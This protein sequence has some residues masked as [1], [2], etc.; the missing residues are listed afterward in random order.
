M[1]L[2]F[3]I[4]G[5]NGQFLQAL[6]ESITGVKEAQKEIESSGMSIQS[7]FTQIASSAGIAFSSI[8]AKSFVDKVVEM[9]S[10]FQDIESSMKVFL[11]SAEK[12]TKFMEELKDAAYYNMFEFTDLAKASQ[13]LIAYKND[14]DTVIPT[15]QKLSDIAVGTKAPLLDLVNLYNRAKNLGKV[16]SQDMAS[17]AVKGIVIRDVLKEMGEEGVGTTVTFEQLNKV[18]DHVTSE[19]G[20]FYNLQAEMMSNISAEIGQ[21]EDNLAS[22]FNEIGEKY[23]EEIVDVI[24]F[25]S[26]L[27]DNYEEIGRVIGE[28]I[29]IYGVYRVALATCLA[30]EKARVYWKGLEAEAAMMNSIAVAGETKKVTALTIAKMRLTN[31][32]K[33]LNKAILANPYVLAAA[34]VAG[35]TYG[36]YKLVTAETEAEKTERKLDEARQLANEDVQ[37]ERMEIDRLF[38]S[39]RAAKEGTEAYT[40]VKAEIQSKYRP[41][42]ESLKEEQKS[43]KDIEGAYRAI[44]Q[45]SRESILERAKAKAYSEMEE[46][47]VKIYGR[48]VEKLQQALNGKFGSEKATQVLREVQKELEETGKISEDTRKSVADQFVGTADYGN[49]SG[50]LS[51]LSVAEQSLNKG[52]EL[53]EQRFQIGEQE[54]K[55]Q[56]EEKVRD[57]QAIEDEKKMLQSELEA[58]STEEANGEKGL[59]IKKK[60][61]ALGKELRAYQ[62]KADEEEASRRQKKFELDQ[63]Q[64]EDEAARSQSARDAII[65]ARIAAIRN[66]GERE[67]AAED[68]QHRLNLQAIDDRE[69]EM[70]KTLYAYNKSVWENQNK[71][72]DRKYSDTEAGKAGWENLQL[73]EDQIAELTALRDKENAEYSRLV[74]QRQKDELSAMRDYLKQYGSFEQQKLAITEEYEQKIAEATTQGDKMRLEREK[75]TALANAGYQSISGGI[76]WKGLF[77]GIGNLSK[78]LMQPMM[79]QLQAYTQT[80][81]YRDADA[82][83]QKQVAELIQE[84]R[85]YVGSQ[86]V[87]WKDLAD[88]TE[89][90]TD[91]VVTYNNAVKAEKDAIAARDEYAAKKGKEEYNEEEYQKLV[92]KAEELGTATA[93]AKDSMQFFATNLSNASDEV[94]NYTSKLSTALN[95]AKGLQG[96]SGYGDI[97]SSIAGLDNLK[98]ALDS[99]LPKMGDGM[100]KTITQGMS[101]AISSGLDTMGSGLGSILSSGIGSVIGA[102]AHMAQLIMDMANSIKNFITGILNTFSEF[103]SL[104][105]IDDFVVA[106]CD[107][108]WN[109]IDTILDLP[110]N[111]YKMV[112]A[113]AVNGIGNLLNNTIGRIGNILSFGALSSGGPA[114]W[115]TNSNAEEVAETTKRLTEANERLQKSIDGLREEMANQ[116][117]YTA[118]N[119][120]MEAYDAQKAYIENQREILDTNQHYHN[121]HHS[122]AYNWTIDRDM[123]RDINKLLS[124]Y[125]EKNGK[126]ASWITPGLNDWNEFRDLSPEEMAYIRTH[127]PEIWRRLLSIGNYDNSEYFDAF[128]DL[129][130]SLEEITQDLY[131]VLTTTTADNVFNDFLDSL[132]DMANGAQDVMDDIADN[133]QEMVNKMVVNNLVGAQFQEKLKA[134]YEELAKVNKSRVRG[135]IDDAEYNRLLEQLRQ[136]YQGYV[137]EAKSEIEMFRDQGIIKATGDNDPYKQEASS[138][139]FQ[140]MSQDVGE[141]MNGRLTAL[142]IAGETIAAQA[143]NIYAEML[144]LTQV[145]TSSNAYLSDMRNM[146]ITGNSYLEDIAKYSKKMYLDFTVK[147]DDLVTQTKN[148]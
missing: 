59:E 108:I 6:R 33:A 105:W 124:E 102:F 56:E 112:E 9:R 46:N 106:I 89:K 85:K 138:K 72:G 87:S 126:D 82:Q 130:G 40:K 35:L 21:L 55:L 111:F 28:A 144:N 75:A 54:E 110:E 129:A 30:V 68:E 58:L 99:T 5:D 80:Q 31:V 115:F 137:D 86:D 8:G 22:M 10:N 48:N 7:V 97:Q 114:D 121:A 26:E 95:N 39:L 20:M 142:Q 104:R 65:Q 140:A 122:N 37:K 128:A 38:K 107:A 125:A 116:T 11:G 118:L 103:F 57:K 52:R 74:L 49:V 4:V 136:Q 90:F 93:D 51:G 43:L 44:T 69:E 77:S 34:A 127:S 143:V 117:G 18:L 41:Y 67:R 16:G 42:L 15:I 1:A 88:A 135:E 141:E 123:V 79:K 62:I 92:K 113:I 32:V 71:D 145:S 64:E 146:M 91:A 109:L 29:G 131:E 19:G 119:T 73:T 13:Q 101:A 63:K 25:G 100:A 98:G 76:D 147:L 133:W 50:W 14:V 83:T 84:L 70:K 23:Q 148:M 60:I 36:I 45:A 66:D 81:E 12:G 53:I 17:W 134:W 96:L 2:K 47:Y 3:D 78:E 132:T 24:Q 27:V 120:A 139:G 61:S 94:V